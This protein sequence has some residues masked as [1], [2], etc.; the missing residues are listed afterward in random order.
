MAYSLAAQHRERLEGGAAAVASTSP[1]H[2]PASAHQRLMWA[3]LEA[4][5]SRLQQI[6]SKQRKAEVKRELLPRYADHLTAIINGKDHSHSESLVTLCIW[7]FDAGDWRTALM[8]ASYALDHR[9]KSPNGFK[10]GLP[11]TLLESAAILAKQQGHPSHLR[12]HLHHLQE[13][14]RGADIADE[15]TA[16]F[17]KAYGQVL[18]PTDPAAA[19]VAFHT[20]QRYGAHVQRTINK[21]SKEITP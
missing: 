6:R 1:T 12:D 9:M 18:A 8:L 20:A 14:T 16:K 19:L 17:S 13:L 15:V 7:A 10:R 3:T 2:K 4:D 11:E 5:K 21:L